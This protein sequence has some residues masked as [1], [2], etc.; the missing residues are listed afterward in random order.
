MDIEKQLERQ[1]QIDQQRE[2]ERKKVF[3]QREA[4]RLELLRQQK[5]EWERQRKHDLENQ[6]LK[7]QEQLSVFK[8]KDKNL[9]Y[10]MQ[11]MNDKIA[12][13]KVKI[14]DTQANLSESNRQIEAVRRGLERKSGEY[15]LVEKQFRELSEVKMRM[16]QEKFLLNEKLKNMSQDSPFAESYRTEMASLRHEQSALQQAKSES[17]RLDAEIGTMRTQIECLRHEVEMAKGEIADMNRENE[18]LNSLLS[19]KRGDFGR[20]AA[21]PKGNCSIELS[22]FFCRAVFRP[23]LV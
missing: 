11:L 8:G 5:I 2:E 12:A 22:S 10:D 16:G 7:L 13:T 18:R 9:E 15:E 17:E 6:K 1:R 19:L 4:A 14:G 3:E 21:V 23:L 20:G